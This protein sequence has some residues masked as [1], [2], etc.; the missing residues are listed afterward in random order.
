MRMQAF[1]LGLILVSMFASVANG[2]EYASPDG[3]IQLR[4]GLGRFAGQAGVP[5]FSVRYLGKTVLNESRLG[6]ELKEGGALSDLRIVGRRE[7][8][9]DTNYEL[10]VGKNRKVRDHHHEYAFT[11]VEKNGLRRRLIV[12]F[13]IFNDG[14]GVRYT[15]P[16]QEAFKEFI[17][18]RELTS[19][20]FEGDPT[21]RALPRPFNSSFEDYYKTAAASQFAI[22][23]T[24]TLPIL[25]GRVG[26]PWLGITEAALTDYAGLYLAP[27]QSGAFE[28]RLA[29]SQTDPEVKVR[30]R[31]P[32][33]SPWRVFMIAETPNRLLESNIVVNLNPPRAIRDPSWIKPGKVQFP[34][35]NSYA[36]PSADPNE[37]DPAKKP[38]V[39][40]WTLKKYIDFCS[41]NGI[42][43][44]SFDGLDIAWYGG[45]V[46]EPDKTADVTKAAP[47]I[48]LQDVLR[49]GRR[50][51][52]R[53]RM[54]M[55]YRA[56][57]NSPDL[58]K[59]F[60]L[61]EKW[62][63]EGIMVDFLDRDDQEMVQSYMKII[64]TAA[65]HRLTV[66]F[67]SVWKPTGVERT[68][69]NL[70]SH[71]AVLGAEY[72][73]WNEQGIPPE[74]ELD[75]AFVRLL[76]G[77]LDFHP[78][79]F[80]P[81]LPEQFKPEGGATRS[82]GTLARQLAI[83]VIFESYAQMLVDYPEAYLAQP[84]AF[85]FV[86]RVPVSWDETKVV[87][88][89]IGQSIA[90]A[91]RKGRDWFIGAFT[92]REAREIELSLDFLG[93]G[94]F[95]VEEYHDT[96]ESRTNAESIALRRSSVKA[97]SRF[98]ISLAPSGGNAIRMT[99]KVR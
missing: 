78:G 10:P 54:W 31:T 96:P 77:P 66:N 58:D 16:K 15:L 33:S 46:S 73:K 32:F 8:R 59:V 51:G 35:W 37:T 57:M 9:V 4:F 44:H 27:V 39:N 83:Y 17:I 50:K 68:Y 80:R 99:P 2:A 70:L 89:E 41:A 72:N 74:H 52:V 1:R 88:G 82:Q 36:M 42:E 93:S 28:A 97:G 76:A 84:V 19:I 65:K 94:E 47:Q 49:Y 90:I 81:V 62:G 87:A 22:E 20:A 86:K 79:S 13:R 85:E 64:R 40:T 30:G 63:V 75:V 5:T 14:V 61:Y 69:P 95:V 11:F 71:E 3:K 45:S 43:Y 21:I 23:N 67:H 55:H 25:V 26:G 18:T 53:P 7:S 34:W 48:D 91:R 56:L 60:A 98:K 38:G 92:N 29:P 6:L 12:T 24:L